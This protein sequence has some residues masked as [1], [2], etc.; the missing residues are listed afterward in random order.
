MVF[1]V[2]FCRPF[3]K[4]IKMRQWPDLVTVLHEPD[5]L[6]L[7]SPCGNFGGELKDALD[8]HILHQ[9]RRQVDFPIPGHA[10]IQ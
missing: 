7:E 10:D 8:L 5:D 3:P 6:H 1:L 9:V 4:R 2:Y